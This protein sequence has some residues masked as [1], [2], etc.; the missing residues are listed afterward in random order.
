MVAHTS[1]I[2]IANIRAIGCLV[3]V[4]VG[5]NH[6]IVAENI[7]FFTFYLHP[8]SLQYSFRNDQIIEHV[9]VPTIKIGPLS[10]N[11]IGHH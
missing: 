11:I 8:F 2:F 4:L 5:V 7:S 1:N 9:P 10:G 3:A 6:P